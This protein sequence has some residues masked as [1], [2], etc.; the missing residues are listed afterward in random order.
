MVLSVKSH[1]C[2]IPHVF[3][4]LM[5]GFPSEFLTVVGLKN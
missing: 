2:F 3:N 4:A 1:N 5:M